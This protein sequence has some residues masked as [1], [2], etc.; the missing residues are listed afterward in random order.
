M[1]SPIYVNTHHTVSIDDKHVIFINPYWTLSIICMAGSITSIV[2]DYRT[3][4]YFPFMTTI[5]AWDK[6]HYVL[7]I[8]ETHIPSLRETFI[9]SLHNESL[10]STPE[11][12]EL[13]ECNITPDTKYLEILR[14]EI[15]FSV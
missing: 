5:I 10:W 12:I 13:R 7:W 3:P 11:H 6:Y 14:R 2:I 8:P 15:W 4:E 1:E 9:V